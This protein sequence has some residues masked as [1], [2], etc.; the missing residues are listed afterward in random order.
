M[1][2]QWFKV[3]KSNCAVLKL[4]ISSSHY[5]NTVHSIR[6][7]FWTSIK[8]YNMSIHMQGHFHNLLSFE[9]TAVQSCLYRDKY[10]NFWILANFDQFGRGSLYVFLWHSTLYISH[11]TIS[12]ISNNNWAPLALEWPTSRKI[13]L[14]NLVIKTGNFEK[15]P[16]LNAIFSMKKK[17]FWLVLYIFREIKRFS[18]NCNR[19]IFCS[20][21]VSCT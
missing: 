6:L 21:Q 9:S 7:C 20:I 14:A 15:R 12:S 10:A 18:I 1:T 3:L 11:A 4:P 8:C 5:I 17:Y 16:S 13:R 19:S 2:I